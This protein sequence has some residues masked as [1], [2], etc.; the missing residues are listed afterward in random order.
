MVRDAKDHGFRAEIVQIP[1]PSGQS[2]IMSANFSADVFG[3]ISLVP[4]SWIESSLGDRSIPVVYI[5]VEEPFS[6]PALNGD[7]FTTSYLLS[8]H[9]VTLNHKKIGL[10]VDNSI[11]KSQLT[12]VI[13]GHQQ[14]MFD[15]GL[16]CHQK[17]ID[18][19]SSMN[20]K[21]LKDIKPFF[22]EF[23]DI[24]ALLCTTG[25]TAEKILEV[26]EFMGFE[27][28][29]Q[30]SLA[31]CQA[32]DIPGDHSKTFLGV[33][34]SWDIIIERCFDILLN[35]NSAQNTEIQQLIYWPHV[36]TEDSPTAQYLKP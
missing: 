26:C 33:V 34:Y 30:L 7:L 25:A 28:P 15:S 21:S 8:K 32:A 22:D 29:E 10:F 19:S 5:G 18:W 1:A 27:I 14:A 35:Q 4:K 23:K 13:G 36:K 20:S 11:G 24:T 3:I 16:S 2:N 6:T 31:C 9:F 17:L 12:K